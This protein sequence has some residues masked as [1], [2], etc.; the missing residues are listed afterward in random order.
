MRSHC[1]YERLALLELHEG[2]GGYTDPRGSRIGFGALVL[3]YY[4]RRALVYA[5][6]VGSGFSHEL[7]QHLGK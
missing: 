4:R 6:K 7:L 1:P 2:R 3:G 5:G